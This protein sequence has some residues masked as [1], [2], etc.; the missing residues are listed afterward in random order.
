VDF[1]DTIFQETSKEQWESLSP[2][3]RTG[4]DYDQML[5]SRDRYKCVGA[6]PITTIREEGRFVGCISY[7]LGVASGANPS[8]LRSAETERV[9]DTFAEIMAIVLGV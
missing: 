6:V 7:N 1:A 2:R 4:M 9:L 3:Q 5:L 8:Q